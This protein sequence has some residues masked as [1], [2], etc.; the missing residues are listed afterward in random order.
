MLVCLSATVN[1]A[2]AYVHTHTKNQTVCTYMYTVRGCQMQYEE[3]V[4]GAQS[5]QD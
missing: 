1:N 5:R 3:Y 4:H 2:L